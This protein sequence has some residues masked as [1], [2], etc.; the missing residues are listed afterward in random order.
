M[1][2]VSKG[3][4][5]KLESLGS[6]LSVPVSLP[7]AQVRSPVSDSILGEQTLV[8]S[9]EKV[10]VVELRAQLVSGLSLALSTEPGHPNIL[11]ATCQA[12]TTLQSPKQVRA[13]LQRIMGAGNAAPWDWDSPELD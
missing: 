13:A 11:T 5:V 2:R 10:S 9:D 6:F 12:L 4:F 8:V 1:G 7:L 3:L